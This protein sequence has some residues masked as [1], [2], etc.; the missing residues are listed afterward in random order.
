M[1]GTV[2]VGAA[3][4]ALLIAASTGVRS[5]DAPPEVDVL[6]PVSV[7]TAVDDDGLP[8][9]IEYAGSLSHGCDEQ[10]HAVD[11]EP[12]EPAAWEAAERSCV[13]MR[14]SLDRAPWPSGV[15]V[16]PGSIHQEG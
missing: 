15:T 3:G 4:L 12:D 6:P 13:R 14:L 11:V 16:L 1:R 8:P 5:G 10:G 7:E 9:R 2:A